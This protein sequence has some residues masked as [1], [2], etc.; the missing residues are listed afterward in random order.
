VRIGL[1]GAEIGYRG[2]IE[3]NEQGKRID[4]VVDIVAAYV[5]RNALAPAELPSVI[6]EVHR[7]LNN[8][9]GPAVHSTVEPS[10]PAVAIKK[11]I[12]HDFL[13]CLEDGL[14]FKSLKRHLR[15]RYG[16]TPEDYRAKWGLTKDYPMVAPSYSEKR[17]SLARELGLGQK[18]NSKPQRRRRK[19]SGA[20]QG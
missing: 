17:S 12:T 2:T 19:T 4:R 14:K 15:I 3:M 18:G 5:S 9:E 11:S 13:I 8:L 7:A 20:T 6:S 16:M 10:V 1:S